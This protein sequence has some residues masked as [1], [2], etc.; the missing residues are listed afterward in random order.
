MEGSGSERELG[1]AVEG[2]PEQAQANIPGGNSRVS[3]HP[4]STDVD[5]VHHGEMM[6]SSNVCFAAFSPFG[7]YQRDILRKM[8]I[9]KERKDAR[10]HTFPFLCFARQLPKQFIRLFTLI[11]NGTSEINQRRKRP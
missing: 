5:P 2:Q 7:R 8:G 4:F 9:R 3:G 11:Q 1:C 6:D 10:F